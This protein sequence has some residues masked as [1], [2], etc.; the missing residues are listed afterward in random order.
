MACP[1]GIP[2]KLLE[3][4]RLELGNPGSPLSSSVTDEETK[5]KEDT[6]PGCSL[7]TPGPGA[8][9]CLLGRESEKTVAGVGAQT[10]W[11]LGNQSFSA[12]RVRIKVGLKLVT[13]VKGAGDASFLFKVLVSK[14][15]RER[16]P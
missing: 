8:K 7:I 9:V 16:T 2:T 1:R 6:A 10:E 5:A 14:N 13:R 4:C 12:D 15:I 3:L 11:G